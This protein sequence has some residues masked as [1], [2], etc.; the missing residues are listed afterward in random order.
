VERVAAVN[1]TVPIDPSAGF[2]IS[3]SRSIKFETLISPSR[4]M[5][6]FSPGISIIEAQA[7]DVY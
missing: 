2:E 3:V 4:L 1:P 6:S 5:I 7:D